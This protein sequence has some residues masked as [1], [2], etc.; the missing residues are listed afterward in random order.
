[1]IKENTEL[2]PQA[3]PGGGESSL[4]FKRAKRA[5]WAEF[6]GSATGVLLTAFIFGHLILESTGLFG[7]KFYNGVAHFMEVTLPLAQISA[8]VV[9][10]LF[11][12]HF[13]YAGRKI[14]GKLYERKRML[15][16][17]KSLKNSKDRWNQKSGE[18]TT[19]KKHMETSL[20][21]W[22]V[23]TGMIILAL[24]AFHLVLAVW[25][26]F[27]DMGI[28]GN[29]PGLNASISMPRVESGLWILYLLLGASVVTHMSVG[30][31]RLAVKWLA[32]T[33]FNRKYAKLVCT[34]IFWFYLLL[35]IAGVLALADVLEGVLA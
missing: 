33:W 7:I 30:L 31:Y 4:A 13:I 11:F 10:L 23:R 21:I 35:N 32:D 29:S 24:G 15:E 16:L 22:Q 6:I 9:P 17:G 19:L 18:Y 2:Y 28:A 25:N 1:M 20:W 3:N 27:T 14:P 5:F 12:V 34:L 26:I 8:F